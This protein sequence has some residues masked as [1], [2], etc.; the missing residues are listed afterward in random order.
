MM[1]IMTVKSLGQVSHQGNK[2]MAVIVNVLYIP[3]QNGGHFRKEAVSRYSTL[4]L[5]NDSH[6]L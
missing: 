5:A 3:V 6:T 4:P 2:Y 1:T